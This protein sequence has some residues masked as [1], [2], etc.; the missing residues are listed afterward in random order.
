MTP[1]CR[2]A[3]CGAPLPACP[4]AVHIVLVHGSLDRSAGMTKL[5]RRLEDGFRVARYDR[6]GYGRS[7]RTPGRSAS[8]TRSTISSM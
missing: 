1:P 7:M 8:T 2:V 3:G 6:R 5:S 4:A